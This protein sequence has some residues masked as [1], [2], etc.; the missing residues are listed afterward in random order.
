MATRMPTL[1]TFTQSTSEIRTSQAS[2]TLGA[3]ILT[4]RLMH[5]LCWLLVLFL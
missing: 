4:S 1:A 2:D 3:A 5:V